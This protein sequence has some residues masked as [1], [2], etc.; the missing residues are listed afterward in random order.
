[1]DMKVAIIGAGLSGLSCAYELERQG[2]KPV[3]FE[4][5]NYVGD[6][7]EYT[8]CTI[9]MF[10]RFRGSCTRYLHK[11][12]NFRI[13]PINRLKNIIMISPNKEVII[14]GNHGHIFTKG[15]DKVSLEKQI[16]KKFKPRIVYERYIDVL[17]IKDN[18]DYIVSATGEF[19]AAKAFG[20]YKQ[21]FNTFSRI[22]TVLGNF[23]ESSITMWMDKEHSGST[24]CYLLPY[25]KKKAFLGLS[26]DNITYPELDYY[27]N[28][29]IEDKNLKHKIT[30]TR[31]VGN[32]LGIVNSVN[33]D[34]VYMVGNAGG[35]IDSFMGFGFMNAIESGILA[36]RSIVNNL[37]YNEL[38]KPMMKDIKLKHEYR[39]IMNRMG[40]KDFDRLVALLGLPIIKQMLYKN[41]L[42]K[43]S[44]G[45]YLIKLLNKVKSNDKE[46]IIP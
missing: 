17:D 19:S 25:N 21:T 24:Y 3:I 12:Y 40:N 9:N 10:N 44:Y 33:I 43:A 27:W 20:V 46:T 23:D 34:N 13:E 8:V 32:R 45:A 6:S 14:K 15:I 42:Y 36:A 18:F 29:F 35:F 31:D 30:E 11:K 16:L 28:N 39:L 38:M 1:M 4:K 7:L 37:D 26:V 41:P 2:I 22:A 5:K